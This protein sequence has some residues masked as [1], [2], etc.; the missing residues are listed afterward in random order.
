T[1][2]R[3]AVEIGMRCDDPT[4]GIRRIRYAS[5]GF[6]TWSEEDVL[7]FQA[8]HP[9][10]TP[11]RLAMTLMLFTGCRRADVV[12]LGR[13][14]MKNGFLTYT[15]HKNRNS[16]PVTLTIRIHPELQ[17]VLDA[18][19]LDNL[20]LLTTRYGKPLSPKGLGSLMRQWCDEAGLPECSAHGLRKAVS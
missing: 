19:P 14:H 7:A 11:A 2:M 12:A 1:L 9:I 18:A 20:T 3:F 10:G 15:Q 13:Q 6:R 17:R 8:R 16:K 4:A 5:Q